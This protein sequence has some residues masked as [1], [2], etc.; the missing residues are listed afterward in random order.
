MTAPVTAMPAD[1]RSTQAMPLSVKLKVHPVILAGGSGTRLWPMSREQYPKQLIGL[2]GEDS[3]LQSTTRRLDALE[4]GHPLAEQLVVVANEEHRFTTAEQLRTSGKPSRLILEPV[5]RDTAPALTVAALSIAAENQDGIMVVM[6]A[7]HA[8]TDID[9]FHAAVAAGV[10]HAAAGHIVTMGIV[11][12]RA[13]TGYGY[14]RIGAALGT[15]PGTPDDSAG[16]IGAHKL[17]R[18]VEKPHLELAQRYIESQEYW[19]NSG[20]FIMRAST[21]L[22]AI[23]HF[24]PAIVEACEAAFAGGKADGDFF[25]LQRDAFSASPSNSIDYAVMEQLGNDQS[26]ASGVVVPLQ[27]GWSDVGSWDAIWDISEKDADQ[28]VGRGRVMFE[29]SSSTFAHSE[30]RLIAC[31]GTQDLVVVET[32]DAILV[33]DKSRVQDVKKIVGRIR[34]DGGLEAANHRKVHRPWGDYDSVDNGERFQVKRIVVKPG[35]RLSLQMHHHRAEH[36]IVVRGTALVT[37]G[38][39]RFIVSENESAYIPLGVTH[40]LENPGKMPLEM[41]EVQSG[42][43]LGEDDIVRFDDTY[44]RQ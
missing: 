41:I 35:A 17:D 44:G 43:Y 39:E 5:G 22:K 19:W 26:A 7:D 9:G 3:L 36:W 11:P 37:R 12:T 31:V 1:T 27:A 16:A 8:V 32:A 42:S 21:W 18:F 25:R 2:L 28:N 30:G 29:G 10:Q 4:A 38:E 15:L 40:R 20:I 6:P 33:A 23:R 13:E 24:Q 34:S 14:I